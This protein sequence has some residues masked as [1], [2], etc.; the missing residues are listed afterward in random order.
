[1]SDQLLLGFFLFVVFVGLFSAKMAV[2]YPDRKHS[3]AK[4]D[5]RWIYYESVGA[6]DIFY[7]DGVKINPRAMMRCEFESHLVRCIDKNLHKTKESLAY[8]NNI[9]IN[10]DDFPDIEI[11]KEREIKRIL[12][13]EGII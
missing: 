8:L 5:P 6:F 7:K 4:K 12:K 9:D 10:K 3:E 1:M 2:M 11:Q 13:N